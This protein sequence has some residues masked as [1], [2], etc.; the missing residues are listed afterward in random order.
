MKIS[1]ISVSYSGGNKMK[2]KVRNSKDSYDILLGCWDKNII[3]L[4]EEFKVLLLNRSNSVLGIYA[5]SKGG[6]SG[7]VVDPKLVFSVALKC[8]ASNIII[9]HNHPSGNLSPSEADKR[10][11]IKL[12]KAGEFLDIEL[13]DHVI[14]TKSGFYSFADNGLIK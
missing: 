8:N 13:L 1:E 10:I 12:K 9:A 6:V 5:L 11:T 3:E 14:I 4:Q 7:T 2:Q